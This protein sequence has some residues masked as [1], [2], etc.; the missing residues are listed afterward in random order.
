MMDGTENSRGR[1]VSYAIAVMLVT[2]IIQLWG[3][4]PVH[5]RVRMHN[6][7][8]PHVRATINININ[9]GFLGQ[10]RKKSS[11]FNHQAILFRAKSNATEKGHSISFYD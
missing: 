2:S 1:N 6:V 5:D 3:R 11:Q 9:I 4:G 7:Y 10:F 8:N